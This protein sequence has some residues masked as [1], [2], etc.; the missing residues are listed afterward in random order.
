MPCR[1]SPTHI[2]SLWRTLQTHFRALFRKRFRY[3]KRDKKAVCFQL[4][5]P[6]MALLV[7][8][9]LIKTAPIH[10]SPSRA[11]TVEPFNKVNG[12]RAA[13]DLPFWGVDMTQAQ[14]TPARCFVPDAPP[15]SH[16]A[17]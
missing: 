6:I 8:L 13:L 9:I 10:V 16:Y 11:L 2:P 5:I 17:L 1:F 15:P 12:H 14:G 4:I 3:A 7:G